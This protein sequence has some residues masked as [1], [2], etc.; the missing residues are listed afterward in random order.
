MGGMGQ[1][2]PPH[3][4][5]HFPDRA[6]WGREQ[7]SEPPI[8]GGGGDSGRAG[9]KSEPGSH[10]RS[11]QWA[12][13]LEERQVSPPIG[14]GQ[15]AGAGWGRANG[16]A[17]R[18]TGGPGGEL[19]RVR[20]GRAG[21]L[22]GARRHCGQFDRY[23]ERRAE[24]SEPGAG[25]SPPTA[26]LSHHHTAGGGAN[27]SHHHRPHRTAAAMSSEAET[28]PPAAPV[29]AAAPAAPADS[30]PN[31]GTGNGGSGLASA[32]PP[33]G[34][35]KKVI[36]E[37]GLGSLGYPGVGGKP[38]SF[39][40]PPPWLRVARAPFP[41]EGRRAP[42]ARPRRVSPVAR[43]AAVIRPPLPPLPARR[44]PRVPGGGGA[45]QD[46]RHAGPLCARP[47]TCP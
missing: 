22:A 27:S 7:R 45:A 24:L 3:G 6:R 44:R 43:A 28:Q 8:R 35:D 42:P 11:G 34:G 39:A 40:P 13:A 10:G 4:R 47:A 37:G 5:A 1:R 18:L 21:W 17:L 38:R 14:S 15:G 29:P 33:A 30:K 36:G 23:R 46:V 20:A 9:E 31:G 25:S 19:R 12:R 2:P 32:A 26:G 41:R 16:V